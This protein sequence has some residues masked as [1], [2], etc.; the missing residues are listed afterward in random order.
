[1]LNQISIHCEPKHLSH[2]A[3][4]QFGHTVNATSEKGIG[5]F[6]DVPFFYVS[7]GYFA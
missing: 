5:H 2:Q 4:D 1:M 3:K 6:G 7:H